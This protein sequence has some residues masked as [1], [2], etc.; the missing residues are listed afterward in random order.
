MTSAAVASLWLRLEK[1]LTRLMESD[2]RGFF[3]SPVDA[4]KLNLPHYHQ[5]IKR[6]M[7]FGTVQRKRELGEY[8]DIAAMGEDIQLVFANAIRFNPTGDL[9]RMEAERLQALFQ[10]KFDQL[11]DE[12]R[13]KVGG[14]RP[15]AAAGSATGGG[16]A[17]AAHGKKRKSGGGGGGDGSVPLIQITDANRPQFVSIYNELAGMPAAALF[18]HPVK[19]AEVPDY[20]GIIKHPKALMDIKMSSQS[21]ASSRAESKDTSRCGGSA[22]HLSSSCAC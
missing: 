8:A 5:V 6:P 13:E 14:G 12:W 11:M 21:P 18:V 16:G 1:Q 3:S 17:S 2:N 15:A 9:V 10:P 20:H 22:S 7:D 19:A 4:V